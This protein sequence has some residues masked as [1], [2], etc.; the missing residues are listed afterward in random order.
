MLEPLGPDVAALGEGPCL[1]PSPTATPSGRGAAAEVETEFE[2]EEDDAA[3]V[4]QQAD[5][6]EE[7]LEASVGEGSCETSG[8][9]A[10][11][12]SADYSTPA[13]NKEVWKNFGCNTEAGR[14]LR[15][16]YKGG[17]ASEASAMIAYPR[18]S[19]PSTRW[20]PKPAERKP[21]PQK[22][23]VNAPKLRQSGPDPDDPRNWRVPIP[24]RK[25][26]SQIL[27]EL[28]AHRPEKPVL[29]RGRDHSVEK[30]LLQNKFQFCGGRALPKGAMG[31]VETGAL[32]EAAPNARARHESRRRK[33]ENG[34]DAEQRE[35]FE[36]LM[37]AVKR[38]QERLK[39]IDAEEAADD[40]MRPSKART[41]RNKEALELKNDV[42]RCLRDIDKLIELAD[43]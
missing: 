20:E 1:E 9:A 23:A 35:I 31:H 18:L 12:R 40:P 19:S 32:P 29:P 24:G 34:M 16:L 36:E 27:A 33:D 6:V 37:L 15:R 41:S 22:A 4:Q 21:C 30:N 17:S 5:E 38:K 13:A 42:D 2:D 3:A 10:G 14:A 26:A 39:E 43:Q 11:S 7:D 28:E 8:T 25:P